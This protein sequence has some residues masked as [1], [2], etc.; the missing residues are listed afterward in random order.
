MQARLDRFGF[1]L[2]AESDEAA[3]PVAVALPLDGTSS[4]R[5]YIRARHAFVKE[6]GLF[7]IQN[8]TCSR[9]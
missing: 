4:P 5:L 2:Q 7:E 9:K 8:G 1:S 3:P 6:V